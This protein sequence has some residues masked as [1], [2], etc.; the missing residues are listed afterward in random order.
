MVSAAVSAGAPVRR[1]VE[2][3][4]AGRG[5]VPSGAACPAPSWRNDP[6]LSRRPSPASARPAVGGVSGKRAEARGGG[7]DVGAAS[8][9]AG[10]WCEVADAGPVEPV[11]PVPSPCGGD[12]GTPEPSVPVDPARPLSARPLLR[13]GGTAASPRTGTGPAEPGLMPTPP[14]TAP[15]GTEP[16]PPCPGPCDPETGP[17]PTPPGTDPSVREPSPVARVAGVPRIVC[18]PCGSPGV[19]GWAGLGGVVGRGGAVGGG[20]A[21]GRGGTGARRAS[22]LM[23]PPFPRARAH[24]HAGLRRVVRLPGAD[25]SDQARIPARAGRHP[26]AVVR[27]GRSPHMR[28]RHST[29]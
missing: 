21:V 4:S 9:G 5:G 8:V 25:S 23:H 7:G 6:P 10:V 17:P 29:G 22:V 16:D 18:S 2:G 20:G 11:R 14:R 27:P 24:P 26:G 1:G 19:G 13:G 28:A 15:S 12:E 3:R